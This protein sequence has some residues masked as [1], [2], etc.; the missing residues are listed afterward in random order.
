MHRDKSST[1]F[2]NQKCSQT[3]GLFYGNWKKNSGTQLQ[4]KEQCNLKAQ[5]MV[6]HAIQTAHSSWH[7]NVR[8]FSWK[9]SKQHL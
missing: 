9:R 7:Q 5:P 3:L 1:L 2:E 6:I 8:L 4:F